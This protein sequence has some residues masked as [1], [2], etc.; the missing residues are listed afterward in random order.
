MPGSGHTSW[1]VPVSGLEIQDPPLPTVREAEGHLG[2]RPQPQSPWV[3]QRTGPP[4]VDCRP[5]NGGPTAWPPSAGP[6]TPCHWPS[7]GRE[8]AWG[9]PL[10]LD[11]QEGRQTGLGQ[12]GKA[13]PPQ[14]RAGCGEPPPTRPACVPQTE[15]RTAVLGCGW[16]RA[17]GRGPRIP[18]LR[19]PGE[20]RIH[21]AGPSVEG[22][23]QRPPEW[24]PA[25]EEPASAPNQSSQLA[26]YT[27]VGG[28]RRGLLS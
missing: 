21:P 6:P 13:G 12:E 26:P 16:I 24:S 17:A 9:C 23:R 19:A 8:G 5:L 15:R 10:V 3:A 4:Q 25:A 7:P 14:G 11:S 2:A 22:L 28:A 20:G 27:G 18:P 1:Q